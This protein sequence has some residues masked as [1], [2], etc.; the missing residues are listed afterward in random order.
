[1]FIVAA[2]VFIFMEERWKFK[3]LFMARIDAYSD[4]NSFPLQ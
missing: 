1:M 2:S 3:K 4:Q